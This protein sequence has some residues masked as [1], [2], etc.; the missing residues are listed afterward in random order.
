M[1]VY[2]LLLIAS[3]LLMTGM[4]RFD[5]IERPLLGKADVPLL[6]FQKIS[7]N[8]SFVLL[9]HDKHPYDDIPE[10]D[11]CPSRPFWVGPISAGMAN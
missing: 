4:A 9:R 11:N 3:T 1:S 6:F 10:T 8:A 5:W 2:G 7:E